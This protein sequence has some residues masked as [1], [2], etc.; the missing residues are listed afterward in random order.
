M[1]H[2]AKFDAARFMLGGEIRKARKTLTQSVSCV[3][4]A[5]RG[6]SYVEERDGF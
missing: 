6:G 1:N 5:L 2:S 4:S 3:L